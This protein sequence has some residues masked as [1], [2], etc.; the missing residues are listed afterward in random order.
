L[1]GKPETVDL[2]SN[3]FSAKP[4]RVVLAGAPKLILP[5]GEV[6]KLPEVVP[7][8][9]SPFIAGAPEIILMKDLFFK[10][11][12]P[13]RFSSIKAMHGL[14][15]NDISS[16]CEDKAGNVWIGADPKNKFKAL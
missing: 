6:Y 1:A 14:N 13:E 12:N 3:V 10:E 15:S 8:I 5:N 16:F 11:N 2:K 4:T 7:A 9:D